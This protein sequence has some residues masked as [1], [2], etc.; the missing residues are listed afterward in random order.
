MQGLGLQI[1]HN[2]QKQDTEKRIL[3]FIAIICAL[4]YKSASDRS[5]ERIR[6]NDCHSGLPNLLSKGTY[7]SFGKHS[8][9]NDP[10]WEPYLCSK[11]G[12]RFQSYG[13]LQIQYDRQP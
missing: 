6:K 7:K 10:L 4:W 1:S 5:T 13:Y 12:K 2:K 3:L 9:R 11:L 8:R